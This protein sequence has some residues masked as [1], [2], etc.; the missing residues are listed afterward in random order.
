MDVPRALFLTNG[1]PERT[2]RGEE[3]PMRT[4]SSPKVFIMLS[5]R[6]TLTA[7]DL[8]AQDSS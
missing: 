2:V 3:V 8:G 6:A 1:F 4:I 5:L 7:E